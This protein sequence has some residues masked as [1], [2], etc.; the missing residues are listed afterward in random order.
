MFSLSATWTAIV[1]F[2]PT[3]LLEDRN[4]PLSLG[5]PLLGFLYYGL[6]P[7]ALAGNYINRKAANRRMLLTIPASL[8]VVLA[9]GI[10]L[11]HGTVP[12]AVLIAGMGLVWIAVPAIGNAAVRV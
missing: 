8:N 7:G 12:L 3:L 1:T 11:T 5:G 10:T 9:L 2:L 6:I 4:M